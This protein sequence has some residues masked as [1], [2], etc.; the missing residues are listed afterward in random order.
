MAQALLRGICA[1]ALLPCLQ[2]QLLPERSEKT[3]QRIKNLSLWMVEMGNPLKA[4]HW[5]ASDEISEESRVTGY[6]RMNQDEMKKVTEHHGETG[7]SLG[8]EGLARWG[9]TQHKWS[10]SYDH[11]E[12]HFFN[13]KHK[14]KLT[15]QTALKILYLWL[16]H[17]VRQKQTQHCKGII[18][19]LKKNY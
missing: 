17:V 2:C 11:L 1:L 15:C 19:Q 4:L 13:G 3:P 5:K 16:I 7:G 6:K 10:I 14:S 9:E 18:L 8:V 12:T